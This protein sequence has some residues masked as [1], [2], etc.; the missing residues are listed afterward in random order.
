MGISWDSFSS[1]IQ[2]QLETSERMLLRAS[3]IILLVV[4]DRIVAEK[5]FKCKEVI[6]IESG[7]RISGNCDLS[8]EAARVKG[9][10]VDIVRCDSEFCGLYSTIQSGE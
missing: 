10:S 6:N 8:H 1:F 9:V 7:D 3:I 5:C 2:V 4:I